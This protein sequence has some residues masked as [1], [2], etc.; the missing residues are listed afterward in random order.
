MNTPQ[1]DTDVTVQA[2]LTSACESLL[3]ELATTAGQ[4]A[5]EQ[6]QIAAIIGFTGDNLRGTLALATDRA[7]LQAI[8]DKLGAST[9]QA[10]DSLGEMTN[11]IAGHV[12]RRLCNLGEVV[13]ITPPT[14]VR[15][16]TIEVCG[17]SDLQ[18]AEH[19]TGTDGNSTVAWLDYDSTDELTFVENADSDSMNDGEMLLF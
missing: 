1:L 14:V 6:L 15:G 3:P 4:P 13:E 9:E 19:R 18:R 8:C 2:S 11:L 5:A 7:G 12:K 10:A 16:V 17:S